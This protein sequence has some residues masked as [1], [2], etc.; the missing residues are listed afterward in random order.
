MAVEKVLAYTQPGRMFWG[1][2][3]EFLSQKGI[4]FVERD[5]TQDA[6]ALVELEALGVMATPVRSWWASTGP[7]WSGYWKASRERSHA[8]QA[9]WSQ[10]EEG[11]H[12]HPAHLS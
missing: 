2:V 7:S 8:R 6:E 9:V 5:V 1:K 12:L 11:R 4:E 3:K 10:G